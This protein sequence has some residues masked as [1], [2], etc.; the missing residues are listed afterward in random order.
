MHDVCVCVFECVCG[1]GGA[2]FHL[3]CRFSSWLSVTFCFCLF[4]CVEVL[5]PRQQFFSHVGME[6][7][8]PGFNQNCSELMCLAQ[9]HNTAMPVGIEPRTSQF[10]VRHSTNMPPFSLLWQLARHALNYDSH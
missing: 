4:V 6:P 9:G 5:H 2:Y 8:L 3:K 1:G 7:T 10:R